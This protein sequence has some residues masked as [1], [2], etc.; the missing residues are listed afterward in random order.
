[1]QDGGRTSTPPAFD[2]NAFATF[3]STRGL[4]YTKAHVWEQSIHTSA[5]ANWYIAPTIYARSGTAGAHDGGNKF[6]LDSFNSVYFDRLRTRAIQYGN[7]GVYV[8]IE[9]F[10]RFSV[11]DGNTMTD[12]WLGHPYNASNNVNSIDGDPTAQG[13]GLD[14]QTLVISEITTRQET[15]VRHLV[16]TL[17]DLD[18]VIWEVAMEPWGSYSRGGSTPV[19]FV[20]HFISYIKTYEATKPKQHPVLQGVF[21]PSDTGDNTYL[22]GCGADVISPNGTG[23]YDHDCPYLDG[24]RVVLVDT[25]HIAWTE[26]NTADWSWKAFTRGAGGFAIMDGGYSTYDDQG[27]GA[28][29]AGTE[30]GRYNLGYI[31]SLV[32]RVNLI[33]MLPQ[34]GG[35]TPS[36]TGYCLKP[37]SGSYHEYVAYQPLDSNITLNLSAE[38]G[39]FNIHKINLLDGSTND[40][41]T[42]TGGASRTITEPS[43]WTGGWVAWVRP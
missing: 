30:N 41:Q 13:N 8:A 37:E 24:T 33:H 6:D 14:V 32:S 3:L 12:Q 4:N 22:M 38:S 31:L 1:M 9:L 21:F 25:D 36:D 15:Y 28:D 11:H 7:I 16:D 39:T 43:G 26:Q 35:T 34:N 2:F 40:A 27:G 10:D 42:T 19:D 18:N 17:N 23:G 5:A 29:F 20:N